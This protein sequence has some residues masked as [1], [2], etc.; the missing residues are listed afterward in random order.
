MTY[1]T[2]K[3]LHIAS[4]EGNIGDNASHLGF[5]EIF[6]T[7]SLNVE[8]DRL[9]IRKSYNNYNKDDKII[10]DDNF[11]QLANQYDYVI[12]G[13]GGFLDYWVD[14][15]ANGTTI[16]I[17]NS[18]L[19]KINAKILITSI[20]SNPHRKIPAGNIEKFK[21]FLDYVRENNNITI[22][23]RNDGSLE[24]IKKDIGVEYSTIFESVLDHGFFY[25]P[26]QIETLPISEK[27]VAINITADQIEMYRNGQESL[28]NKTN[29]LEELSLL[30]QE[31]IDIH[32]LKVVFTSHIYSDLDAITELLKLI[33]DHYKRTNIIIA[34][35]FQG[36]IAT[37]F[38]FNIYYS[39]EYIIASRYHANVCT[40][41]KNKK[42]IG[43]SPLQRIEH[44][45]QQFSFSDT[46]VS[47]SPGFKNKVLRLMEN[48]IKFN[49]VYLNELK[50]KTLNFYKNYFK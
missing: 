50:E 2:K 26:P 14:G 9:E 6:K 10:F 37:D 5:S 40:I 42:V 21:S 8:I 11:A 36:D 4:F 29:Y 12:F 38:L 48:E 15:S 44:I 20:G 33:P 18:I 46:S 32:K 16:N 17:S 43:L 23:L 41:S 39:S 19:S 49:L 45:H 30:I 7:L 34:P 47:L 24:S 1:N 22:A 31:I 35:F 3:I 13:G 28:K 27:F 25:S